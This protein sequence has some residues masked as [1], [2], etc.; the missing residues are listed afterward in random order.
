MYLKKKKKKKTLRVAVP[1]SMICLD[2]D[3]TVDLLSR[4]RADLNQSF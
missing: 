1:K 2:K 4:E 3:Q